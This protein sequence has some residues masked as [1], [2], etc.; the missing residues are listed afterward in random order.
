MGLNRFLFSVLVVIALVASACSTNSPEDQV[1]RSSIAFEAPSES[2]TTTAPPAS[3]VPT[4]TTQPTT[5]TTEP[6]T[7]TTTCEAPDTAVFYAVTGVPQTLNV[8]S[9]PG[10]DNG[11]VG[12]FDNG[13]RGLAFTSACAKVGTIA[14]W[15]LQTGEGW[16]A[17]AYV[18][19][20]SNSV[21][22]GGS[23]N[24]QGVSNLSANAGEVDGDGRIDTIYTFVRNGEL[25]IAA[26]LGDGGY[27]ETVYEEDQESG[28]YYGYPEDL[29]NIRAIRPAGR[30]ADILLA[31]SSN[32][33]FYMFGY[34]LCELPMIGGLETDG[35]FSFVKL[36]TPELSQRIVCAIE[37]DGTNLYLHRWGTD[38]GDG[39]AGGEEV[40]RVI[41][42]DRYHAASTGSP[43]EPD[44]GTGYFDC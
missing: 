11:V 36:R 9:G 2:T 5:T 4:T 29:T 15:Q 39:T 32:N 13:H 43:T 1:A 6:T 3:E 31:D 35:P 34:R 40:R 18:K 12:G 44:P 33:Q 23:F 27:I 25:T 42:D 26:E 8:R 7:T 17:S 41:L 38:V 19:P 14:W 37:S 21:C 10:T 28:F 30:S 24:S 22:A 20:Q 16:L